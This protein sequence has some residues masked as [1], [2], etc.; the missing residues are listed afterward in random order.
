M[1]IDKAIDQTIKYNTYASVKKAATY[2]R[3]PSQ[4]PGCGAN[5]YVPAAKQHKARGRGVRAP[6]TCAAAPGRRRVDSI[7]R[8]CRRTT[9]R[10]GDT[11]RRLRL[12]RGRVRPIESKLKP[13]LKLHA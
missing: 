7:M 6:A 4:F 9:G 8:S 2:A 12:A 13:R 3:P 1:V 11:G 5:M 10:P